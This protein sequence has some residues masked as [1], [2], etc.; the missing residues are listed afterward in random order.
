MII[1]H[2]KLQINSAREEG[3]LEEVRSLIAKSR[4]EEG[5]IS[6]TL[7]KDVD[8]ENVFTM[9]EIWEDFSAVERHNASEHFQAFVGKA[10]EYLVAPLEVKSYE[11][12]ELKR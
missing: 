6:Y 12:N 1:T 8:E 3:F 5:N 4:E 7:M 11:G 10:P 2:A 9:V